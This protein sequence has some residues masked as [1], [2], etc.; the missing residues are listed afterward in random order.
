MRALGKPYATLRVEVMHRRAPER[1]G[2]PARRVAQAAVRN[3]EQR[4]AS[5]R[6][7]VED[8]FRA[9][10]RQFGFANEPDANVYTCCSAPP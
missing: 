2:H 10:K 1:H 3:R 5:V 8:V 7:K 4:K 6:A 9:I